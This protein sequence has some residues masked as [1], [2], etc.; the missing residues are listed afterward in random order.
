LLAALDAVH[1]AALNRVSQDPGMRDRLIAACRFAPDAAL[2]IRDLE[3][4]AL[5][6]VERSGNRRILVWPGAIWAD[7]APMGG[8]SA[9]FKLAPAQVI[10]S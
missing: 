2:E 1:S 4:A 8:R 10:W 6:Q 9:G 7:D 5:G 3:L